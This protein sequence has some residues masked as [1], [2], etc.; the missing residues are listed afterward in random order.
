MMNRSLQSMRE[1]NCEISFLYNG[2]CRLDTIN[3][4]TIVKMHIVS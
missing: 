2:G 1:A 3:F 4:A